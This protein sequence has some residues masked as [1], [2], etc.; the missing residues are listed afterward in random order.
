[1]K[2]K[3]NI[4]TAAFW[5]GLLVHLMGYFLAGEFKDVNIYLLTVYFNMDMLGLVTLIIGSS[6]FIRESG[7]FLMVLGTYFFY[8][9]FNNPMLW[10]RENYTTLIMLIVNVGFLRIYYNKIRKK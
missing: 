1:M 10:T 8:M 3:E 7:V 5:I 2:N 4:V 9:E 6:V